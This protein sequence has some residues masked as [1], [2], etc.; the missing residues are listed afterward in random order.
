[1]DLYYLNNTEKKQKSVYDRR[2]KIKDWYRALKAGKKCKKCKIIC[3]SKHIKKFHFHHRNPKDKEFN[4]SDA[5]SSGFAI[6]TIR[7]E[8]RKCEFMCSECHSFQ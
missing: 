8:M 7:K 6:K 2:N 3:T 4:I 5:V 1:L